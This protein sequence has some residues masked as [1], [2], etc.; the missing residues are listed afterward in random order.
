MKTRTT[1]VLDVPKMLVIE[2]RSDEVTVAARLVLLEGRPVGGDGVTGKR[3]D[4]VDECVV[5]CPC[6][7]SAVCPRETSRESNVRVSPS[8][9]MISVYLPSCRWKMPQRGPSKI[10]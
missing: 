4:R 7:D 9:L 3:G 1:R 10:S 6:V 8:F 2:D 5:D